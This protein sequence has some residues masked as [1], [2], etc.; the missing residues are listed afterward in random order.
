MITEEQLAIIMKKKEGQK[1]VFKRRLFDSDNSDYDIL[2]SFEDILRNK[3]DGYWLIRES[4]QIGMI[5]ISYK[6]GEKIENL[7]FAFIR[8]KWTIVPGK[9]LTPEVLN[10]LKYETL[11]Q[12]NIAG[13]CEELIG[14][15]TSLGFVKMK[16]VFPN[17]HQQSNCNSYN[18]Y[19]VSAESDKRYVD[20]LEC[21]KTVSI[22]IDKAI[23]NVNSLAIANNKAL[24]EI[25]LPLSNKELKNVFVEWLTVNNLIDD[26]QCPV[27][28]DLF[29]VP[30]VLDSGRVYEKSSLFN[31]DNTI[32]LEK[33]PVTSKPIVSHPY[34]LEGYTS[35]LNKCLAKFVTLISESKKQGLLETKNESV[36]SSII[37][38]GFVQASLFYND[39][40]QLVKSGRVA[41]DK[42]IDSVTATFIP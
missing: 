18:N 22:T 12:N 29:E 15:C 4:R 26:L 19:I 35:S 31:D 8:G 7:R 20:P 3:P 40:N 17:P 27:S 1:I 23:A 28:F 16:L 2:T 32:K 36:S 41:D 25:K 21:L 9:M 37:N 14:R 11:Y 39:P 38:P 42:L 30:Y 33:C 34:H 6:K 5:S 10:E 13:K 24:I